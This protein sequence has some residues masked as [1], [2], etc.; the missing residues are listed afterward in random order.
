MAIINIYEA[1]L[2]YNEAKVTEL[3]QEE[4]NAGTDISTIINDGLII[5]MDEVGKRYSEG[6]IFIPEMLMAAKAMKASLDLLR[7]L[8]TNTDSKAAGT[9][10]I[11]TVKGDLHDIGKNLVSMMFEGGGFNVI[12]LGI[13]VAP[14]NFV[15]AVRE[16]TAQ[17][18]ALSALLTTTMPMIGE[19]INTIIEAG[20]RDTVKVIVGGAPVTEDFAMKIGADGYSTDAPSAVKL[21][22]LLIN[23]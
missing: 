5:A 3:V 9:I 11:G 23:S 21:A 14:E 4:L 22:R 8:L 16:N 7:P 15:A 17:L 1:V 12:D 20:I 10:V 2:E 19:T 18:V 6:I 13:D